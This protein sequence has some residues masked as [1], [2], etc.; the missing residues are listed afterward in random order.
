MARLT[1]A[2]C[3]SYFAPA[4]SAA[5]RRSLPLPPG[6]SEARRIIPTRIARGIA[7]RWKRS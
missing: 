1:V 6:S 5:I 2:A 4:D 3:L 7:E